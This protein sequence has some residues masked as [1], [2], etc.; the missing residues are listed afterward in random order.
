MNKLLGEILGAV[1]Y[2]IGLMLVLLYSQA[3]WQVVTGIAVLSVI[4]AAYMS[5]VEMRPGKLAK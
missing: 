1:F 3:F 2:L 5:W 4:T